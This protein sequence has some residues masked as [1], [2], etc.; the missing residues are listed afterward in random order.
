[1][2]VRRSLTLYRC[3]STS[4]NTQVPLTV[5]IRREDPTRIWE[6][7]APLTPRAVKG[8]V[9]HGVNV[10]FEHCDRRVFQDA[11]YIEAGATVKRNLENAHII[12]GIKEAPLDEVISSPITS[13][14]GSK[15]TRSARTHLM[16]SHTAKGQPYN[17]PL[18][19]KFVGNVSQKALPDRDSPRLIDYELLTNDTDGKR[20]V[21]FGWFAGVA[22]ALESLS[23][24]AHSHLETGVASPF[25][26]TPRPHTHPSLKSLRFALKDIKERILKD[27][28]PPSLGPFVI[29]LTGTG[30]VSQGC[31]DILQELPIENVS[32]NE[33]HSLVTNKATSLKKIYV[34]HAMPNDYFV[35]LNGQPYERSHYYAHPQLYRSTFCETVAPYLTLFLNGT[36]WSPNFPRL[37][38]NGQLTVALDRARAIG[39]ARF[40]NIG[41]IS[42]DV[43]GGLEFLDRATTLSSPFYKIAPSAIPGGTRLPSIQMMSVDILPASLPLD[44]SCHFSDR[45]IPYLESL[46]RGYQTGARDEHTEALDRATISQNGM[47]LSK[48]TWLQKSVDNFYATAGF[49]KRTVQH[50]PKEV[51][52]EQLKVD[53]VQAKGRMGPLKKKNVLMLGSGMVA[54][55]AVEEIAKRVD[56]Q[57]VVAGNSLAELE[58]L[59]KEYPNIQTR[60]IE[61]A[62]QASLTGLVTGLLPA[63]MHPHIAQL[64]ID[65]RKHLVTA[66]YVSPA[67][68]EL[69]ESAV[70]ADVLLLNEIGLDPGIDH[71]SAID[72]MSNLKKQHKNIISFTSFCGG[73][74]APDVEHTPLRYKFSWSPKGVLTA[75]LNAATFKLDNVVFNISEENLLKKAFPVVPVTN[76]FGLEG[77]ANRNSLVYADQY[78]IQ[79]ARTVLRG[80][81]RYPGFASLM[82]SFR[83]TGFLETRGKISLSNWPSYVKKCLSNKLDTEVEYKA[84]SAAISSL[85][86]DDKI[87]ELH[88]ALEWLGLLPAPGR[89]ERMPALPTEPM[90]AID[91]FA[92]L[93]ANKLA[94]A[95][96]ERDMVVLSH[97]IITQQKGAPFKEV[98]TSSLITY[99]TPRA[100]AMARTVGIPVAIA[101]LRVVDGTISLRG[102]QGPTDA[103]VYNPVL[104]GLDELG[105]GMTEASRVLKVG[106]PRT[107]EATLIEGVYRPEQLLRE[108]T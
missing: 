16:F 34:V 35:Q 52:V 13:P 80:T 101:A 68:R 71:C 7:R 22:G 81:L 58:N 61:K 37:M 83:A 79:D 43:E 46:I 44:A 32:V 38:T 12:V 99:G 42:C 91:I 86:G 76:E 8:L 65:H 90:S 51:K 47:L 39:G 102:V 69:N 66:S 100:S 63:P 104:R 10:E 72:L 23:S 78:G 64:C 103:S 20:T 96:N 55:P 62:D 106:G 70:N 53:V 85:V 88:D 2:Y 15:L 56:I 14:S 21:G 11:E 30:N 19:A 25:L 26:S 36:G 3:F 67:M 74:P 49:A 95:P 84:T 31:L 27:G 17:V 41:D 77:I 24:M 73:L 5:G 45:L 94:Y 60:V 6:R 92:Y 93:L 48:H 54:G 1:M 89:N 97:E 33:L 57:L 50:V 105:L 98:H 9:S 28:T 75:A 82:G 108:Q 40:T 29:G 4:A 107:T 18:L 87:P 59:A